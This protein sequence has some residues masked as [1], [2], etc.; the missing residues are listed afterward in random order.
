MR[1]EESTGVVKRGGLALARSKQ[2]V[3]EKSKQHPLQVA[4]IGL[5]A[6]KVCVPQVKR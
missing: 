1:V 3:F 2:A 5:C 6:Q 4:F